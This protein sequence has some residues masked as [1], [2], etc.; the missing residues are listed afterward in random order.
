MHN[1]RDVIRGQLDVDLCAVEV[2]L[3]GGNDRGDRVFGKF[4]IVGK[5]LVRQKVTAAEIR[6]LGE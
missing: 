6:S 3:R 1:H 5:S 2:V 4:A